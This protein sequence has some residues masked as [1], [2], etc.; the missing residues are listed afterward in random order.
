MPDFDH[1]RRFALRNWISAVAALGF[2]KAASLA[3]VQDNA[4]TNAPDNAV[5]NAQGTASASVTNAPDNSYASST[6]EKNPLELRV[7]PFNLHPRLVAGLTYDDNILFSTANTA[8]NPKESDT[9]W[10]VQPALQAVAGDDADLI[11]LRDQH[12][13]I[14]SLSPGG[15]IVQRPENWPGKLFILDYG[16]RFQIYDKYT[17]NNSID[18]L[19][20]L[21][22]LWP[23]SKLIL[24]FKQDYQLEKTTLIE[25]GQR[26]QVEN[27]SSALSAAYQFGDRRPWKPISAGSASVTIRR[28]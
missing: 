11:A 14:L 24:G 8:V 20:T 23:M 12:V 15:L 25:A 16:P 19:G 2:F 1:A 22:F 18:Q 28:V 10:S 4:P 6:I 5:T 7:G 21:N 9:I 3:A 13:D 26:A 17:A 27:I